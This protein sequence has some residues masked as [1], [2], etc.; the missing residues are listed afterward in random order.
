MS[1][2]VIRH[3]LSEANDRNNIGTPAFANPNAPLMDEGCAQAQG[4]P[5]ALFVGY[6]IV[7]GDISVATSNMLRTK[8][9][10]T[11][12]GFKSQRAYDQL[13]EIAREAIDRALLKQMIKDK[14]VPDVALR[15]AERLLR[16]PPRERVWVTHGLLIAGVCKILGVYQDEEKLIQPFCSIRELPL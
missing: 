1:K 8:Q 16:N 7:A 14:I 4:I 3:G 15:A 9:T 6:G 12:A 10:A 2:I 5:D 11:V 13:D